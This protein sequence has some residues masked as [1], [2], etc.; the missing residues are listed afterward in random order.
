MWFGHHKL[1]GETL[2]FLSSQTIL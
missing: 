1:L 2:L